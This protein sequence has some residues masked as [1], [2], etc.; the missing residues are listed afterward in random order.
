MENREEA[1]DKANKEIEKM[2]LN[3][4]KVIQ[5]AQSKSTYYNNF[6]EEGQFHFTLTLQLEKRKY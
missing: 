1:I 2:K 5:F 4:F 3:G 6:A